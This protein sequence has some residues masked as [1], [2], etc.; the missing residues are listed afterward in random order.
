MKIDI[1]AHILPREWPNLRERYGYGGFIQLEHTPSSL[2]GCGCAK[3]MKD[4]EFFREVEPNLW[5]PAVRV[6][7]CDAHGVDVQVLSTVPVM[8][9]YWAKPADTHD[10][11]K[12]LN[13]HIADCV[14]RHPRRFMGL[15]TV[16]MQAPNRAALELERCINDLGM[17]GVEI[18]THIGDWNLDDPALD[19]FWEA[20]NDLGAAVFVH[21]WD[22]MGFDD[23]PRHWLP[24]LVSMPAET[25]RAICSLTMGGVLEKYPRIRFAFAHG[26]GSFPATIGRIDHGFEMR[27]DLCQT[28]TET[29]PSELAKRIYIDSL[30]HD[31][32]ALEFVV[33]VMGHERIALGTDYPFPLG[34]LAPGRL[35]ESVDFLSAEAKERMLSGTA[36]EW[37]GRERRAY[38]TEASRAHSA[39]IGN[40]MTAELTGH[41]I[42]QRV[43]ESP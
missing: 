10:L 18:G 19:P 13:D 28:C 33:D 35:I 8:F 16:P 29:P 9:S 37:A 2:K 21:P 38:E 34:E 15:G 11:S 43:I 25:S 3:M 4:D 5:D 42:D 30:V 26:G 40:E 31:P 20:A 1:H 39:S 6:E 24:W 17:V 7:E 14:A 36:L 41:G 23:L 22:M 32:R 12:I 27:P